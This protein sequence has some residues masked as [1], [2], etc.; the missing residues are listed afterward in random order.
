MKR[1]LSIIAALTICAQPV[2]AGESNKA[3]RQK[4]T[5]AKQEK[6]SAWKKSWKCGLT[7]TARFAIFSSLRVMNN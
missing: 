2:L 3:L 5:Q 4:L 6:T 1:I 7:R